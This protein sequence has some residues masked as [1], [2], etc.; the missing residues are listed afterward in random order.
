LLFHVVRLALAS[1]PTAAPSKK[2]PKAIH[3]PMTRASRPFSSDARLSC[4]RT[5][6]RQTVRCTSN[7]LF[8]NRDCAMHLGYGT[9]EFPFF[10]N[11]KDNCRSLD[12]CSRKRQPTARL[13]DVFCTRLKQFRANHLLCPIGAIIQ[14]S[15]CRSS[16][17]ATKKRTRALAI[18]LLLSW[19][20]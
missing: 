15:Q 12:S 8:N 3:G 13:C 18:A 1:D 17:R 14:G 2:T 9:F 5:A 16:S 6:H 19:G 11:S 7:T 4:G 20:Q 10:T